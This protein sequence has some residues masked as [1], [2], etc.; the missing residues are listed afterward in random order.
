MLCPYC[1]YRN[2]QGALFC[3]DCGRAQATSAASTVPAAAQSQRAT[4][5]L[6]DYVMER[7]SLCTPD[8][9]VTLYIRDV[10]EPVLLPPMPRVVLGRA[11]WNSMNNP[12]LDLT[13]YSALKCGVSRIHAALERTEDALYIVDLNSKNGVRLNGRRIHP[14]EACIIHNGDELH[15]GTL[16]LHV[17]FE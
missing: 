16:V 3:E 7:T 15:L 5:T 12:D 1:G 11:D 14:D 2:L 17:Y 4:G 10:E 13:P 8:V 6:S 9:N